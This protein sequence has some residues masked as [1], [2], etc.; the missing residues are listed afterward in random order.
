[1]QAPALL[2]S[3]HSTNNIP[4]SQL[5]VL[6]LLCSFHSTVISMS[7]PSH[8]CFRHFF[9]F[10]FLQDPYLSVYQFFTPYIHILGKSYLPLLALSISFCYC[11]HRLHSHTFNP[12]P[13]E[14]F[15]H[16]SPIAGPAQSASNKLLDISAHFSTTS[17][18]IVLDM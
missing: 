13:L 1:M 16:T 5:L 9:F 15:L 18:R 10:S 11:I 7:L 3:L 17:L 12:M 4:P 8:T 6:A 14:R 2:P